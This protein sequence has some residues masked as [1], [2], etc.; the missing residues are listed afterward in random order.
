M[1]RIIVCSLRP[2]GSH[3]QLSRVTDETIKLRGVDLSHRYESIHALEPLHHPLVGANRLFVV[4]SETTLFF[5]CFQ[6][7]QP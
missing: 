3:P 6:L 4:G 2:K 7:L 5:F 1:V